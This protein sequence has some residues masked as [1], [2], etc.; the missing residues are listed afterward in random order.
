MRELSFSEV[1]RG[2][3]TDPAG[4]DD[5]YRA[6]V[7]VLVE[8]PVVSEHA[9]EVGGTIQNVRST[10]AMICVASSTLHV[11]PASD[12]RIRYV[13]VPRPPP[14]PPPPLIIELPPESFVRIGG[15]WNL[16]DWAWE[17]AITVDSWWSFSLVPG[18]HVTGKIRVTLLHR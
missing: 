11:A 10:A 8:P 4:A 16:R 5:R 14:V 1:I 7:N 17:G 18:P 3:E 12:P 15:S 6:L 2:F 13:G 9:V